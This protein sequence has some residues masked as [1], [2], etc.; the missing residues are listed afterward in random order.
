[1]LIMAG[2]TGPPTEEDRTAAEEW[3]RQARASVAKSSG[4]EG[5][6]NGKHRTFLSYSHGDEDAE[7]VWGSNAERLRGIKKKWDPEN[8]FCYGPR[9]LD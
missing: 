5:T 6:E 3:A 8:V 7:Q 9:L 4:F 2:W 1:M